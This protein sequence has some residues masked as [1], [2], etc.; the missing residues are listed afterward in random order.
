MVY[1]QAKPRAK[2]EGTILIFLFFKFFWVKFLA[3]ASEF[4]C[5]NCWLMETGKIYW[6][7]KVNFFKAAPFT[8]DDDQGS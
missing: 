8:L 2:K 4:Q 6:E 7:L 5:M 3:F 1:S